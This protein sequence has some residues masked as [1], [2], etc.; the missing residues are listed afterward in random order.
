MCSLIMSTSL[1]VRVP[2]S[3]NQ[4]M[5]TVLSL[6]IDAARVQK[7]QKKQP[8]LVIVGDLEPLKL[9]LSE[10]ADV[11]CKGKGKDQRQASTVSPRLGKTLRRK[12][13][14]RVL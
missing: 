7:E 6:E 4:F 1:S 12:G 3:V 8:T 9:A 2:L 10:L 14:Q 11:A 13:R 5:H